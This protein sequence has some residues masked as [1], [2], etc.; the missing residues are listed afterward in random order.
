M[1]SETEAKAAEAEKAKAAEVK[2]PPFSIA[3][4]KA[5]TTKRGILSDGDEIKAEDLNGGQKAIDAFVKTKHI[6]KA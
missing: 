4:G 5:I 6:I 3:K 1:A 2:K